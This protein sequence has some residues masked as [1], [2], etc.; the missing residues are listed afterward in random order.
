[1]LDPAGSDPD[2]FGSSCFTH[3]T[4]PK[5]IIKKKGKAQVHGVEHVKFTMFQQSKQERKPE[6]NPA[7]QQASDQASKMNKSANDRANIF[8]KLLIEKFAVKRRR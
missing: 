1:M 2:V 7:I 3:E 4:T 8:K 5:N 6:S